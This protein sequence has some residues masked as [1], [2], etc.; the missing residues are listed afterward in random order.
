VTI[1]RRLAIALAL[2]LASA[3]L[4][5]APRTFVAS[6]GL[7]TNPCSR[8]SPCR[9]F[10]AA[11]AVTDVDGEIVVID[12]AGYGPVSISQ[13]V[14]ITTPLGVYAGITASG[15]DGIDVTI[16][17]SDRVVLKGLTLNGVSGAPAGISF[18]TAGNLRLED[19]SISGFGSQ[20]VTS[21]GGSL[22]V[23]HCMVRGS[24]AGASSTGLFVSGSFI[25]NVLVENS[26][27]EDAN[28]CVFA[29]SNSNV[30]VVDSYVGNCTTFALKAQAGGIL[31]VERTVVVSSGQGVSTVCLGGNPIVRLSNNTIMGNST[32]VNAC[33]TSVVFTRQN[34]TIAGNDTD[35]AGSNLAPLSSQ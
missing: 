31:N 24:R 1:F 10:T 33:A 2:S 25:Q 18:S 9:S 16:G 35:L 7:D 6:N 34:N 5:A 8:T 27:I 14:F 26:R 15:V 4:H 30:T 29:S 21:G 13:S 17:A 28:V 12:S 19:L 20:I 23:H 3:S 32:G 22:A 11:L